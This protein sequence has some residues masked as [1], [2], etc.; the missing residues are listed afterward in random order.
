MVNAKNWVIGTH[1]ANDYYDD[2]DEEEDN[3]DDDED[4]G[5]MCQ[6]WSAAKKLEHMMLLMI[7]MMRIRDPSNTT[8]PL[9][10]GATMLAHLKTLGYIILLVT[11]IVITMMMVV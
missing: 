4:D 7:T 5:W 10:G 6:Q 1:D 11:M 8:F 9:R 3:D 2:D